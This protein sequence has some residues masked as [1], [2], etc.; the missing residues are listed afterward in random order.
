MNLLCSYHNVFSII[1]VF[2]L[3]TYSGTV[4]IPLIWRASVLKITP[5]RSS[6]SIHLLRSILSEFIYCCKTIFKNILLKK[7]CN[8]FIS[9]CRCILSLFLFDLLTFIDRIGFAIWWT[10]TCVFNIF[11]CAYV[12]GN[13]SI[14]YTYFIDSLM[15]LFLQKQT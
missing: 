6:N 2:L 12:Y 10:W 8:N 1:Y 5:N 13:L 14:Y 11:Y 9:Q 3:V 4:S 7:W 15:Q